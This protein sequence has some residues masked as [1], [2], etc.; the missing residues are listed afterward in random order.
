M[1]LGGG[2][3]SGDFEDSRDLKSEIQMEL[4]ISAKD[5]L[6]VVM[7]YGWVLI[8]CGAAISWGFTCSDR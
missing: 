4:L 7:A 8:M 2:T 3:E 1:F 5:V 6:A